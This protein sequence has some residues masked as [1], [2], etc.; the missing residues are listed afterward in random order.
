VRRATPGSSRGRPTVG[1]TGVSDRLVGVI[2]IAGSAKRSLIQ[3]RSARSGTLRRLGARTP[4]R[5]RRVRSG[6]SPGGTGGPPAVAVPASVSEAIATKTRL[7]QRGTVVTGG[8]VWR[9]CSAMP[10][11][12]RVVL[13][14]TARTRKSAIRVNSQPVGPVC[15][16]P[17]STRSHGPYS[18][19]LLLRPPVALREQGQPPPMRCGR[20]ARPRGAR[21]RARTQRGESSPGRKLW[22]WWRASAV[23]RGRGGSGRTARSGARP[24]RAR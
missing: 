2:P 6:T 7:R 22:G 20:S 23:L 14:A 1:R 9:L 3:R 13:R 5:T 12:N 16:P 15:A 4:L 8:G 17:R 10:T 19:R 24:R 21:G 18:I 11:A